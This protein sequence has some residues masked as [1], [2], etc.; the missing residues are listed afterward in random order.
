M[1]RP[2]RMTESEWQRFRKVMAES[3]KR[4]SEALNLYRPLPK[5]QA[6]H[7]SRK[8]V[9]LVVGGNRSSKTTSCVVEMARAFV[10]KDPYNKYTTR[11]GVYFVFGIDAKHLGS[12][13]Y[14]KLFRAG[15]FKMIRDP[16]TMLWR[17]F[18][19]V[20]DAALIKEAK[21]APPLIPP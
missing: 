21:P 13:I 6:F 16:K 9:R 20:A 2:E 11:N 3:A 14:K 19:P 1:D 12:V 4:Q 10:G 5:M 17:A 15:A 7:E 18:D 8:R